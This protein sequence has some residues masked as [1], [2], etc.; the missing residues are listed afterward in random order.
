MKCRFFDTNSHRAAIQTKKVVKICGK[1]Y[2]P[3]Q[4]ITNVLD[5]I[6]FIV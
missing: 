3:Q 5:R 2:K 1:N 6:G 4:K